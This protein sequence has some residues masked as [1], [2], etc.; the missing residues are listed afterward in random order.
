LSNVDVV[1]GVDVLGVREP[2]AVTSFEPQPQQQ[3]LLAGARFRLEMATDDSEIHDAAITVS[4]VDAASVSDNVSLKHLLQPSSTSAT[5][6]NGRY[7]F[8]KPARQLNVSYI[9][10]YSSVS[11]AGPPTFSLLSTHLSFND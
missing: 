8:C 2:A 6:T 4:A 7:L 9:Y 5:A 11:Q 10:M 3:Q 1:H